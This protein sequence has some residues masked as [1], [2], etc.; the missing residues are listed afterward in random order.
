[1]HAKILQS[2]PQKTHIQPHWP[3]RDGYQWVCINTVYRLRLRLFIEQM[4]LLF[5]WRI[6]CL[7]ESNLYERFMIN[8]LMSLLNDEISVI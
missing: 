8:I 4:K 2:L 6:L 5:L 3:H 7:E 1:M